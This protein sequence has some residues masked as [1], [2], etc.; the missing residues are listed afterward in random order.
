MNWTNETENK[1]YIKYVKT[2]YLSQLHSKVN[3]GATVRVSSAR[4]IIF[5]VLTVTNSK[6]KTARHI[7]YP[8]SVVK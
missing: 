4:P 2:H 1:F 3:G 5:S 7:I 6:F 8:V